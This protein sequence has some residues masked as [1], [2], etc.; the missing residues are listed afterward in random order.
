MACDLEKA[1]AKH[2]VFGLGPTNG[3][4]DLSALKQAL[5]QEPKKSGAELWLVLI[6]HGTFDGQAAKFNLRGPDVS[7]AAGLKY[8]RIDVCSLLRSASLLT[9]FSR[10]FSNAQT[11]NPPVPHA[12][13]RTV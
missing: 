10:M 6:G 3:T 2:A 7:A 4:S 8:Y 5:A 11:K 13:S 1:C 12:G 9:Y